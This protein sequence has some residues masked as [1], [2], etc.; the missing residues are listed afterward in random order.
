[1]VEAVGKGVGIMMG[2]KPDE[3]GS[4]ARKGTKGSGKLINKNSQQDINKNC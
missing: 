1:M 4:E 3:E 2:S